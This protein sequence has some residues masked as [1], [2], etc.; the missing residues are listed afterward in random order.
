[1]AEELARVYGNI[2]R[3]LHNLDESSTV[4]PPD[5]FSLQRVDVRE[6]ERGLFQDEAVGSHRQICVWVS[7][8][9]LFMPA[10]SPSNARPPFG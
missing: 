10:L 9:S 8:I 3:V 4:P 7:A 5:P 2:V 1:M 6:R